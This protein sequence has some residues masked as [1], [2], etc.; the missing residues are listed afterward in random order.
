MT[1]SLVLF[2]TQTVI[3]FALISQGAPKPSNAPA[4]APASYELGSHIYDVFT[5]K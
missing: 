1:I 2:I 4:P 5:A 3:V